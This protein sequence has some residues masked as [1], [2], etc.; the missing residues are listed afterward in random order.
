MVDM[1]WLIILA[2]CVIIGVWYIKI[3]EE[4]VKR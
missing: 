2:I 3:L 4:G 1:V